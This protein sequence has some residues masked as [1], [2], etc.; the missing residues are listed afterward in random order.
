MRNF[1]RDIDRHMDGASILITAF[2]GDS[3]KIGFVLFPFF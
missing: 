3:M 2:F 1:F